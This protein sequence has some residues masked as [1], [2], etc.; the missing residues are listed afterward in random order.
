MGFP[1]SSFIGVKMFPQLHTEHLEKFISRNETL[2]EIKKNESI[3]KSV[4][5]GNVGDKNCL[6]WFSIKDSASPKIREEISEC[7]EYVKKIADVLIVIGI[8]GSNRGAMAAI[9]ALHRTAHSNVRIVYAGDTMSAAKLKDVIEC[10]KNESVVLN[11][12]A[13]NFATVEPGIT[14]RILRETLQQKYGTKDYASRIIAT[15]SYGDEQLYDFS[16]KIGCRFLEFPEKIGGRYSVLSA[17]ELFPMACAGIDINEML[18]SAEKTENFLKTAEITENPA[19]HYAVN[20]KLLFDKGFG[21]E[22]LVVFEPDLIHVGRWWTQLFAE[23]EGKTSNAIFPVNFLYS[24]DLHAV[25]QYVQ[26]GKK[27]ITETYLNL[28]YDNPNFIIPSSI[29]YDD[30][31]HYLTSKQFDELNKAVYKAAITAHTDAGVPCSEIGIATD[32]SYHTID[33]KSLGSLFYFFMFSCY[34]SGIL[35]GVNPFDQNG[36]EY[37]K[38]N[39]YDLLGKR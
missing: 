22:S 1:R 26:E 17:V 23:S 37:Y 32:G 14:F 33:E 19:V 35:I 39:M 30:G 4:Q 18:D 38:K 11:V 6:G 25:G 3:L 12:I 10:V 9:Q 20:R 7:A 29:D 2:N 27:F 13:K 21:I 8:G 28:F 34:M 16:K 24:E 15:G 5:H 31:F 36:V